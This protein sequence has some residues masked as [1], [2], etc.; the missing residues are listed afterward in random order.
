[1]LRMTDELTG[2][3]SRLADPGA[4]PDRMS[5]ARLSAVVAEL[6]AD[7]YSGRRVGTPGGTAAAR[8][9]ADHLR[10]LG[11]AVTRDPVP[12]T[13]ITHL[14]ATPTLVWTA[15]G[16]TTTGVHR[17]DFSEHLASADTPDP[18]TAEVATAGQNTAGRWQ[19]VPT[20]TAA[21]AADAHRAGA[22]GLILPR[23][24]DEAGWM[25][26]MITA[27]P[28]SP[29][30]VLSLRPDIHRHI[31]A[32]GSGTVTASVPLHTVEAVGTNVHGTFRRPAAGA[33]NILLA[34]HF[35]GVGD[36]PQVR[37]PAACDNASGIAVVIE[38][39]R[40][41]HHLLPPSIGLAVALLDGEEAG[42]VG[43]AH[44]A[45]QVSADTVV[46]NI[47]GAASLTGAAAVEA[48]GPAHQLLAALDQ[49]GAATGI[50]LVAGPMPSDNR[51]Y[52]AAG[53][54]SV[55][56]GM[57]LPGYQTP[58]ETVDRVEISTLVEAT[59]L[60]VATVRILTASIELTS[61]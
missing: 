39:A 24:T 25:P 15:A 40:L 28:V 26:K 17:R 42:A 52:A 4:F 14:S 21:I 56:I 19:F 31:S 13:T 12:A 3:A 58:A 34:A 49:A 48:G 38:A 43:S 45:R 1:M 9:L 29:L 47:D 10:D 53:L 20:Y 37:L 60:T 18:I 30:P 46:I 61:V 54:A 2:S 59:W 50:P 36:D 27:P 6:A 51:R 16:E 35:D 22:V 7:Q 33:A 11:A 8:W 44:H 57:G 32:T 41:L 23:D 5:R 55:G